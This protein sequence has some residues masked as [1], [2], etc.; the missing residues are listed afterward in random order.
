MNTSLSAAI[1][2]S[3]VLL[4][5]PLAGPAAET[6][7]TGSDLGSLD[8]EALG[9]VIREYLLA[10]PEVVME[11]AEAYQ[12]QQQAAAAAK[13]Q[14]TLETLTDELDQ[15]AI[16][17]EWGNPDGDITIVEFSDYNCG[18]C[19][20]AFG[21]L[22]EL[23]K[24][25]DGLRVVIKELP[26]LAP[27]SAEAAR[28]ALAANRQGKFAEI[29]QSLMQESGR[30]DAAR[31]LAAAEELGLDT[32]QLQSEQ[33]APEI[34]AELERNRELAQAL[35]ISGTPAFAIGQQLLPGAVGKERM[36]QA[37]EATRQAATEPQG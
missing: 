35:G 18:Y 7:E 34:Q 4:L 33:G 25:D 6:G 15:A 32:D 11:A 5:T 17:A 3:T 30:I 20:R 27:E 31:V 2:L 37:I 16:L 8:R 9:E 14:A 21:T 1:S 19:K 23:V 13:R 12:Q 22:Q 24:E 29:H 26:I 28:L 10:N 36:L